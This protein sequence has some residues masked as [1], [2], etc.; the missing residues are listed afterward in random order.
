MTI[1]TAFSV[2]TAVQ[3]VA[4]QAAAEPAGHIVTLTGTAHAVADKIERPLA[5]SNPVNIG[6][7]IHTAAAARLGLLLGIDTRI[8]LGPLAKLQVESHLVD[9]GGT[10]EL[11]EGSLFFAHIRPINVRTKNAATQ[12]AQIRSPY[13]LIAVRGTKFFAG[14]GSKGFSVFVAEGRVDVT[15]ARKTVRLGPGQGTDIVAIGQSPSLPKKWG[16]RRIRES[17]LLTTGTPTIPN[18]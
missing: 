10:F 3:G 4:S 8:D 9:A 6:D 14:H 13:G 11:V 17:L 7:S 12:K 2:A 15:A 18:K 1:V 5:V 16:A